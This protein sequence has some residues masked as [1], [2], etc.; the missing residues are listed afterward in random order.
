MYKKWTLTVVFII[1][2]VT[3]FSQVF[4]EEEFLDVVR[5]VDGSILKGRI[6][7][8]LSV[9]QEDAVSGQ[10][11]SL[12]GTDLTGP[13]T[14]ELYGGSSFVVV[15]ANVVS[16]SRVRNQDFGKTPR[17]IDVTR[18]DLA[19]AIAL[20]ETV[21]KDAV[22]PAPE[23]AVSDAFELRAYRWNRWDPGREW[24]ASLGVYG[25]IEGNSEH[26]DYPGLVGVR[27]RY[28]W[29]ERHSAFIGYETV[30]LEPTEDDGNDGGY[31]FDDESRS[32]PFDYRRRNP[33]RLYAGY[34]WRFD[35]LKWAT[36]IPSVRLGIERE[37]RIFV[38][39]LPTGDETTY[40]QDGAIY[41]DDFPYGDQYWVGTI[42]AEVTGEIA[43]RRLILTTAVG[44]HLYLP[45]ETDEFRSI[46]V[47]ETS[48]DEVIA[49]PVA[50]KI[51]RSFAVYWTAG[52]SYGFG[53]RE[54]AV[55]A[56]SDD[57]R[58][59]RTFSDD[60]DRRWGLY[61][62]P[63]AKAGHHIGFSDSFDLPTDILFGL[64]IGFARSSGSFIAVESDAGLISQV[65]GAD[66]LYRDEGADPGQTPEEV[67]ATNYVDSFRFFSI[68][69]GQRV[70]LSDAFVLRGSAHLDVY[71]TS[72]SLTA[73]RIADKETDTVSFA[74]GP[75]IGL[76]YSLPA[77]TATVFA[78]GY[79]ALALP[80]GG[81][82]YA[83]G[84]D[85]QITVDGTAGRPSIV[86]GT[87]GVLFRL[88]GV[89]ARL[90]ADRSGGE[91][92]SAGRRQ[93]PGDVP[94]ANDRTSRPLPD[95]TIYSFGT[96]L[97]AISVLV[98]GDISGIVATFP[99]AFR[100]RNGFEV[101]LQG[102]LPVLDG[103]DGDDRSYEIKD[104]SDA[105]PGETFRA[106]PRFARVLA[107]DLGFRFRRD[108]RLSYRGA[109]RLTSADYE[110]WD[111]RNVYADG[112]SLEGDESRFSRESPVVFLGP[113]GEVRYRVTDRFSVVMNG[114]LGFRVTAKTNA[115]R[116]A[117]SPEIVYEYPDT[118]LHAGGAV[119]IEL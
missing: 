104:E 24:T 40:D 9:D 83:Y 48:T 91:W 31:L 96:G 66:V 1:V 17:T 16:I 23:P 115:G 69:V 50:G 39:S 52:V 67:T 22:S 100:F 92:F 21:E 28:D 82:D 108:Q 86:G 38:S 12:E 59:F 72:Y 89:P 18:T 97:E 112:T 30:W 58:E 15:P 32:F 78:D 51:N 102:S 45:A 63:Q 101:G 60:P 46:P 8:G 94:D 10:T 61:L 6:V 99:I 117:Y 35:P 54:D 105:Q 25:G 95:R 103:P 87:I 20:A 53:G 68:G 73:D 84:Y 106:T 14:I 27:G 33:R 109:L 107:L 26:A 81:D 116:P 43:I 3:A 13:V 64:G 98:G 77:T 41:N 36:V 56:A 71:N 118:I 75:K 119:A 113:A 11:A 88:A 42:G 85:D 49:E 114:G 4:P 55:N 110:L 70:A 2:T 74:M 44:G 90:T 7:T 93:S 19:A 5:M 76:E 111:I 37:Q 34:G 29:G 62:Y 57:R 65:Y 47:R 80:M 79:L